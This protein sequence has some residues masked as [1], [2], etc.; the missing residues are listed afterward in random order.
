MI[1][2]HCH[3]TDPRLKNELPAVL[4]RAKAAGVERMLT[5]SAD[6]SEFEEIN[7]IANK[8][9]GVFASVGV[10]PNNVKPE[11]II[12]TTTITKLAAGKKV[13]GIG[14]TGLDYSYGIGNKEA[15]KQSF[16]NHIEAARITNL[17][18]IIHSREAEADL[19][20]ILEE[21]ML[22]SKF[23][24]V[25]HC[26]TGTKV[27]AQVA[28]SLG[29]YISISGI[30]TFK[31]AKPLQDVV[32]SLPLESLLVETDAPYLAPVPFRGQRNEPAFIKYT[33]DFLA[34]LLGKTSKDVASVTTKNFLTLFNR[35][36][37][38]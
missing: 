26:F 37:L 34:Q 7:D 10:H 35:P 18:L 22:R 17:P 8:H 30:I 19:I 12:G 14:E 4:E 29:F 38:A 21:E 2:S 16:L 9:E 32:Q 24:G 25:L 15:Q 3:L 1:D 5:I 31:N 6:I 36:H 28:L 20:E 27:L 33:V 23:C 13:I 11:S